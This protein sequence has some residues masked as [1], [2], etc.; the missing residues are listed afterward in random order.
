MQIL[1]LLQL[2]IRAKGAPALLGFFYETYDTKEVYDNDNNEK[3]WHKNSKITSEKRIHSDNKCSSI[4]HHHIR[5]KTPLIYWE[6]WTYQSS[7]KNIYYY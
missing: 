2:F 4:I 3:Y 5:V 7:K 6:V 1:L